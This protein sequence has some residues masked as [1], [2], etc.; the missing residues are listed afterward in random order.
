MI[1]LAKFFNNYKVLILFLFFVTFI[2]LITYYFL[3]KSDQEPSPTSQKTQNQ[4]KESTPSAKKEI[5][6][7]EVDDTAA[8]KKAVSKKT[9]I[10]ENNISF[11]ISKNTG[12]YA[13]GNVNSKDSEFGGG[14]WLAVKVGGEW[15]IVYDGQAQPNCDQVNP[16][17]FPTDIVPECYDSNLNVQTR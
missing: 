11:S 1:E 13:T 5:E 12:K 14:Y 9:G 6:T 16:Y 15:K 4:S 2:V 17:N 10:P 7:K 3:G 8:L